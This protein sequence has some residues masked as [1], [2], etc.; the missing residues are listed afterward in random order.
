[1][2]KTLLL[3]TVISLLLGS[4]NFINRTFNKK[5]RQREFL[6]QMRQ[7]SI[8]KARMDSIQMAEELQ[9]QL[10]QDRL[11]SL[12]LAE[13]AELAK[14]INKYH[15]IAGSFKIKSNANSFAKHMECEGYESRILDGKSGFTY[16]SIGAFDT[17]ASAA[18]M[19][20]QIRDEGQYIV[21]IHHPN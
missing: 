9:R 10:E 8:A 20:K 12:R 4:C 15:I 17:F 5:K 6:E 19:V 21:W 16:V 3:V 2:K 11:D 14:R 18:N 13:E 7:D 1:M